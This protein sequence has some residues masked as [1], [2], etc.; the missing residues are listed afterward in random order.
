V[1][2]L[3]AAGAVHGLL[4]ATLQNSLTSDLANEI[5][6]WMLHPLVG[7][8]FTILFPAVAI[9]HEFK[10]PHMRL[11]GFLVALCAAIT[12]LVVLPATPIAGGIALFFAGAVLFRVLS[13][14]IGEGEGSGDDRIIRP[15]QRA[16]LGVCAV[17]ALLRDGYG[18]PLSLSGDIQLITLA[19]V[20]LGFGVREDFDRVQKTGTSIFWILLPR[21]I[22]IV[23]VPIYGIWHA[24]S[25]IVLPEL[26]RL[27]Y[28]SWNGRLGAYVRNELFRNPPLLLIMS[29]GM[30]I[31]V[32]TLLLSLP[33]ASSNGESIGFLPALFTS[34][35]ATCVTGLAVVDTGTA[36]SGFGMAVVLLLIQLGGLGIITISAFVVVLLDTR[37]GVTQSYAISDITSQPGPQHMK[38]LVRFVILA[39]LGIEAVG[40]GTLFWGG[41]QEGMSTGDAAWFGIFHSVSAF[42]NAGFALQS[43]SLVGFSANPTIM[44]TISIL[45]IMGGLGFIPLS[46][47]ARRF[48]GQKG[49]LGTHT[50]VALVGTMALLLLG[51]V[52]F[53]LLESPVSAVSAGS[54]GLGVGDA[55][56]QSI[57]LRTAGFNSI[58]MEGLS[59]PSILLSMAF[60][61]IGG[62]PGGTAGGIKVTTLVIL[63]FSVR[64]LL[65]DDTHVQ[66]MN[67]TVPERTIVRALVVVV[68]SVGAV[69]LGWLILLATQTGIPMENLGF[70]AVSAYGTVGLSLNTTSMLDSTGQ[71]VIMV[72]M[73]AGR[74]G[75]LA[76]VFGI[77]RP[78]RIRVRPATEDIYVG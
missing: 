78:R 77:G 71:I 51:T 60:M 14:G 16:L 25:L 36:F 44:A 55:M 49:R 15:L 64:A 39:T 29:F 56:F 23:L 13:E 8:G 76:M 10:V 40:A 48:M 17:T 53:W 2:A 7:W 63:I 42:C 38:S 72:L 32:G 67:R 6:P 33:A 46:V 9:A 65:R 26:V 59:E 3:S 62:C 11:A 41:L 24:A 31:V 4:L 19:V 35:S 54:E 5:P 37:I 66:I 28:D 69:F 74:V 58:P 30:V 70:E 20:V 12:D 21:M 73:F 61:F 18:M 27:G 50:Q 45:V 68:I 47:I 75:P 34:T 22:A 1:V 52:L 57:T 43:D